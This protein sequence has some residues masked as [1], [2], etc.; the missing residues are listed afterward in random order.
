MSV[1]NRIQ[2]SEKILI[3][4]LNWGLGHATRCIP[5]IRELI[6]SGKKLVLASDGISLKLLQKE[7]PDLVCHEI[8]P[9]NVN[10]GGHSMALSI[11]SQLGK[12]AKA[13]KQEHID[14]QALHN[15]YHF[16]LIISDNRYGCYVKG[17]EN[18]FISHQLNIQSKNIFLSKL[19]NLS[20]RYYLKIFDKIWVP[21]D[22]Q[23]SL[24]GNLSHFKG[25]TKLEYI[26]ALSRFKKEQLPKHYDILIIL[27]GLEPKRTI[28]EE[29]LLAELKD[30][31]LKLCLVRGIEGLDDV[32]AKIKTIDLATSEKLNELILTSKLII[33]RSGYSSIMDLVHLNAKALLI[34]TPGQTEQEY[35]AE[36]LANHPNFSF[37]P[38]NKIHGIKKAIKMIIHT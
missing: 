19:A 22:D 3:A 2:H 28:L 17:I 16:D 34:P 9:Y 15:K 23:G 13:I 7:F 31:D 5:I 14:V 32:P 6:G 12:I 24:S 29:A 27:S 21:D 18:I 11:I 37:I 1:S 8:A 38:E 26:G 4:V 30:M 36:H 20:I 10:Y 25:R 33:C 35:L